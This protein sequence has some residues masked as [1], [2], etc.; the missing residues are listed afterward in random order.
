VARDKLI[1][2]DMVENLV[3]ENLVHLV[4]RLL[5]DA[6]ALSVPAEFMNDL[7]YGEVFVNEHVEE[8]KGYVAVVYEAAGVLALEYKV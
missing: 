5:R 2:A 1:V 7:S 6:T 8:P 4:L 3:Q